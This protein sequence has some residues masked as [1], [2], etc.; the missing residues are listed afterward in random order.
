MF[1]MRF[2]M[3]APDK[4][5]P[6]KE[7]YA[8]ALDMAEWGEQNG[9]IAA[10]LCEHHSSDDGYLPSPLIMASA[11]AARTKTIPIAIAIFMLPMYDPVKLAEEMA[12]LDI[13]SGGRVSYVGGIGY[14]PYEYEMF[15]VDFTRRGKIAEEKLDLLLKIKGGDEVIHEGRRIKVT[16][17]PLSPGGPVVGWGGGSPP[18]ARRAGKYGLM[19]MA[20]TDDPKL[21]EIYEQACRDNGHEVG[22]YMLPSQT[23][24]TTTF[25]AEDVDAAWQELG[26]YI[27]HDVLTYAKWNEGRDDVSSISFVKTAEE[28]RAQNKS[29]RIMSVDQAVDFV[30][31]GA[32]LSL[33]P[34]AGGLPPEIAWKYLRVVSDKV[35]PRLG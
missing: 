27:M 10:T 32:P 9:C 31:G 21:G 17:P 13:I 22:F 20:Q 16:P 29:H 28:L 12:V 4:G 19:F 34:L 23:A 5:A 30:R 3:R 18:A 7:L 8:A 6:A 26:S 25:V 2:D 35:M 24:P 11:M 15:G 33:L 1:T 14:V